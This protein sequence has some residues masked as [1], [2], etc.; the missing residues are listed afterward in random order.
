MTEPTEPADPAAEP[1]APVPPAVAE[2]V[3]RTKNPARLSLVWIVPLLAVVI[4]ASLL[5]NTLMQAGPHVT[6]EFRTAEGLEPGKTEVRYK[7]V[8]VGRVESVSLSDDRKRVV[9]G[10]RLDRSVSN[11]AV[12]D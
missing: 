10:V 8:V 11:I 3:V 1:P 2:P 12:E 5:I 7:E 6:I 4:G 9:A